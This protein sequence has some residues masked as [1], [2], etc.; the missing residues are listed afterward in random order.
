MVGGSCRGSPH[1]ISRL[2]CPAR[3]VSR[4]NQRPSLAPTYFGGGDPCLGLER[5]RHLVDAHIVKLELGQTP[6]CRARQRAQDHLGR[7]NH[8]RRCRFLRSACR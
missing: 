2:A 3:L 6:G 4:S 8:P 7:P 5:L 1:R